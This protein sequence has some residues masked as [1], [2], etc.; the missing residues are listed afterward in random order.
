MLHPSVRSM[1]YNGPSFPYILG[2]SDITE[3]FSTNF[4]LL[5]QVPALYAISAPSARITQAASC[6]LVKNLLRTFFKF[7][8]SFVVQL[9]LFGHGCCTA[10]CC[11]S[12]TRM[13]PTYLPVVV[14]ALIC[15]IGHA[16][17]LKSLSV[18]LGGNPPVQV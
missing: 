1:K 17:L 2:L 18:I 11:L 9:L 8:P 15:L 6:S 3:L 10:L 7:T 13:H 4:S 16:T 12:I 14:R 5:W